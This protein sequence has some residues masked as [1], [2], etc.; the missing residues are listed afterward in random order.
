[1]KEYNVYVLENTNGDIEYVGQTINPKNRLSGHK[2]KNGAFTNRQDIQMKIIKTFTNSKEA[3]Y[4]EGELKLQY[5]FE[6][7]EKIRNS[8]NG[9]LN[10]IKQKG[11]PCPQRGLKGE[12]NNSAKLTYDNVQM[13]REL[14]EEN[15]LLQKD[16]AENFNVTRQTIRRISQNKTWL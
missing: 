2:S 7:T 6:W 15:K 10:Y 14:L 8:N 13:I 1:M 11:I 4:F 12:R 5:G 3:Y 9:T 16:I